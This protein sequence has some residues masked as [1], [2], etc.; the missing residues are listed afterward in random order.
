MNKAIL[1][2]DKASCHDTPE[3]KR[4][5]KNHPEPTIKRLPKKDPNVNPVELLVNRRMSSAVQYNRC[6][7]S[8]DELKEA[9]SLFLSHYN[10]QYALA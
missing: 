6:Y 3:V 8:R 7:Y 10:T 4:F 2:P 9:G 1:F 5:L